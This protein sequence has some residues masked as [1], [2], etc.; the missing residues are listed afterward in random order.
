[1]TDTAVLVHADSSSEDKFRIW[2]E[3]NYPGPNTVIMDPRWHAPKIFRAAMECMKP[4]GERRVGIVE[5]LRVYGYRSHR[6]A[7]CG[8]AAS[9]DDVAEPTMK[10]TRGNRTL[11][12]GLPSREEAP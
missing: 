11:T 3:A 10:P 1:M 8:C 4:V 6:C 9:F 12:A 5:F 7:Y 2:F